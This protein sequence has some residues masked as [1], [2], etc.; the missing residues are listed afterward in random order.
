MVAGQGILV[1]ITLRRCAISNSSGERQSESQDVG[2]A[3]NFSQFLKTLSVFLPIQGSPKASEL[4]PTEFEQWAKQKQA[5]KLRCM[6]TAGFVPLP[7]ALSPVPLILSSASLA[8][9]ADGLT[10]VV[11]LLY[12]TGGDGFIDAQELFAVRRLAS[13]PSL[14]AAPA[15]AHG[16]LLFQT[17]R[18]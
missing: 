8:L 16:P 2:L 1:P 12:D 11:F 18:F 9:L 15:N 17:A 6:S 5:Q 10:A 7:R 3:I 14:F 13:H 4:S